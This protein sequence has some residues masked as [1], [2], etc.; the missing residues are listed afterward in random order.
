M[1]SNYLLEMEI[2][3]ISC[4]LSILVQ[5]NLEKRLALYRKRMVSAKAKTN[6]KMY[7]RLVKRSMSHI[8]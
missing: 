5:R 3:A 6:K 2:F 7:C 4:I 1:F 8:Q